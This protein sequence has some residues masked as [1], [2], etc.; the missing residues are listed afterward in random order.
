MFRI[1]PWQALLT[2]PPNAFHV[3]LEVNASERAL[4]PR[5]RVI[6][7]AQTNTA[8]S[9]SRFV[10]QVIAAQTRLPA[11]RTTHVLGTELAACVGIALRHLPKAWVPLLVSR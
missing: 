1:P 9:S 11:S 8:M 4:L 6:G 3:R 5:R 7:E 2:I 10:P